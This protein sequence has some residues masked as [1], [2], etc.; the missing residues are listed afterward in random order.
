[1][2]DQFPVLSSQFRHD[3]RGA[4]APVRGSGRFG[5]SAG[6]K[7]RSLAL[8]IALTPLLL[9]ASD[10]SRF[11]DLGHRMMC[12]CGCNQILLECNHV[13]CTRSDT[14]RAQL[15]GF[16]DGGDND[17][18]VL[19]KF[20]QEYGATVIAAPL[21]TGFGRVAWITPFA[22]LALALG[23]AVM[24]VKRWQGRPAV[25][26]ASSA[27]VDFLGAPEVDALRARARQET[28]L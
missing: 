16:L 3:S 26:N 1:M 12:V 19:Q 21:T 2:R 23:L 27:P 28:E 5:G 10:T 6:A 8:L 24:V 14:M 13:G 17:S 25:A 22:A 9:A 20:V 15:A 7:L 4:D 11:N 18:L